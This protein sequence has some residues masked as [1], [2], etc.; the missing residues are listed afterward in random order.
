MRG[1]LNSGAIPAQEGGGQAGKTQLSQLRVRC[2][3]SVH[4][5]TAARPEHAESSL[6]RL[7]SFS[8]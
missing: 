8:H 7:L 5:A 1:F 2:L 4:F 3:Q 6:Q